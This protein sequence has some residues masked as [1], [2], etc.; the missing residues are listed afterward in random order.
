MKSLE[1][2]T[3]VSLTLLPSLVFVQ[4]YPKGKILVRHVHPEQHWWHVA[5]EA[6]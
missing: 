1:E 5:C 2:I 6:L 3:V 4:T